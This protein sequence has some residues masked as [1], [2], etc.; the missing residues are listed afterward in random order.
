[1]E[2]LEEELKGLK[3]QNLYRERRLREGL[4]D[5][6]SNDYLGLK[7]HP[8]VKEEAIKALKDYG[9]GSGA[10]ALVSGYTSHHR[11]LEEKLAHFKHVPSCVLFG[12]GYLANIGTIPALV[13]EGDLILSDQLNH[14]SIIDACRLSR[15]KVLVFPHLNYQRAEELLSEHRKDY[16]R[17]LIVSDSVF[18]MDGDI[19]HLPTLIRLAHMYDCMLLLDEAHA[20]GVLGK[21][22]RGILEEF[23]LEWQESMIL[24][25]TLSKA[26]GSYGAFVCASHKLTDYL[27]NR[28]RSLIFSTSLPPAVCAGAR[29]AIEII[30]REP[31]R[32]SRVKELAEEMHKKLSEIGFP[33]KFYKTP[34][35]PIMVYSEKRAVRWFKMLFEKGVFLQAIRYPTVPK[36]EARLRLTASLRYADEDLEF[37]Y[38]ALKTP[39]PP[40][41]Y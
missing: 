30:E 10:S 27:V 11:A 9:L 15:A 35:L 26:V 23:S 33:L 29:K 6:C 7:D 24:M 17:C 8:E 32:V 1:M 19:A 2:W 14:A 28:A 38:T 37:L 21:R 12:S 39:P 22:G 41:P 25:G 4:K 5:F 13:S 36:G 18:S 3:Q 16:R 31:W 34:I 20:T 40:S